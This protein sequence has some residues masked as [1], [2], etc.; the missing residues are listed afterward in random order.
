LRSGAASSF[1]S[2]PTIGSSGDRAFQVDWR[3][4]LAARAA[5]ALGTAVAEQVVR[6]MRQ[7]PRT[8]RPQ[9]PDRTAK[10]SDM[11]AT[12]HR[13]ANGLDFI[14]DEA[15]KHAYGMYQARRW[16]ELEILAQGILVADPDDAWT[17]SLRASMLQQQGKV[18]EALALMERAHALAPANSNIARMRGELAAH[19]GLRSGNRN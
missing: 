16:N 19:R 10:D 13:K 1:D 9:P 11:H 12:N 6:R 8:K 15:R 17:I 3:R 14:L 7:P 5:R 2:R 4:D 18:E